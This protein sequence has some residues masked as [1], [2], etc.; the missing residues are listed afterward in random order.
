MFRLELQTYA[1]FH[2]IK[3]LWQLACIW[4]QAG[5]TAKAAGGPGAAQELFLERGCEPGLCSQ[6]VR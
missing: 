6:G 1:L 4:R 2:I 3:A 5:K